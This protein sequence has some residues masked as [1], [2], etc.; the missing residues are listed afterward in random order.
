MS[1][2]I[3]ATIFMEQPILV[4]GACG[5]GCQQFVK[6]QE[7]DINH[8]VY[9]IVLLISDVVLKANE[10]VLDGYRR[11]LLAVFFCAFV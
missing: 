10:V 3:K 4:C 6:V 11:V 5:K 8:E 7:L 1:L 9:C 2:S